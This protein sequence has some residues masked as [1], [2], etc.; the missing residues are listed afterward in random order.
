MLSLAEELGNV[1]KACKYLGYSWDTFYRYKYIFETG[2][3]LGEIVQTLSD[4]RAM[5]NFNDL[6]L[7]F[8]GH[9]RQE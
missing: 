8:L 9:I 7:G 6:F 1:S 4:S 3:E 5:Q 2:G